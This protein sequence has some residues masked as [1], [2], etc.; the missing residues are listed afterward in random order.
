MDYLLL[1]IWPFMAAA[2]VL[3]LVSGAIGAVLSARAAA[4][5]AAEPRA[6]GRGLR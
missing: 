1:H 3:G 4:R 6:P 5:R 2:T